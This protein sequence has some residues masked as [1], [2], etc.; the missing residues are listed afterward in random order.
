MS[1]ETVLIM[2]LESKLRAESISEA[3]HER[4]GN[5]IERHRHALEYDDNL[6]GKIKKARNLRGPSEIRRAAYPPNST[7][8]PCISELGKS[9]QQPPLHL[10]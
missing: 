2:K 8:S 7:R 5:Y 9:I 6:H 4:I 3:A 10:M 1:K